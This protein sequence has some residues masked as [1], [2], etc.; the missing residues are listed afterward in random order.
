MLSCDNFRE[1]DPFCR[2]RPN[3]LILG[4]SRFFPA[5]IMTRIT[6]PVN[7]YVSIYLSKGG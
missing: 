5:R 6:G 1:G 3:P 4:L 2:S 7:T